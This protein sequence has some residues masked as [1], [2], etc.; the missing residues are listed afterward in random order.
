MT[1][2][3]FLV[4]LAV[5]VPAMAIAQSSPPEPSSKK[6][7][8]PAVARGDFERAAAMVK[9]D[10]QVL[11]TVVNT[12]GAASLTPAQFFERVRNCELRA[13]YAKDGQPNS[14]VA[15]WMC[16]LTRSKANPNRSRVILVEVAFE[17]DRVRLSDYFQQDSTR[18]VPP[19]KRRAN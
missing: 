5:A 1:A 18:P 6:T 7:F 10:V 13:F 17:G 8:F 19:A 16:P 12:V 2:L 14:T 3:R 9:G 4:A 11:S 15:T